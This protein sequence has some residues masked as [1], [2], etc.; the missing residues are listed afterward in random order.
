MAVLDVISARRTQHGPKVFN[1][2]RCS[3]VGSNLIWPNLQ[4]VI[5]IDVA[6]G[7]EFDPEVHDRGLGASPQ[8]QKSNRCRL[9]QVCCMFLRHSSF[10][11]CGTVGIKLK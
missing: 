11:I 10:L 7:V 2:Y 5:T 8:Y 1:A 9:A 6:C 3:H 4:A